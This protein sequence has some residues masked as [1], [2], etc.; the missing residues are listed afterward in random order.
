ML[1]VNGALIVKTCRTC[2][3]GNVCS[4]ESGG[5]CYS[6]GEVPF[7]DEIVRLVC[8]IPHDNTSS[9]VFLVGD[10]VDAVL[11]LER[12]FLS[13]LKAD[14]VEARILLSDLVVD[15]VFFVDVQ[16]HVITYHP[17]TLDATNPT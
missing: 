14:G 5:F 9:E 1:N 12:P 16:G 13:L 11:N 15:G 10:I 6:C 7:V 17:P 4:T 2:K 3:G 8:E